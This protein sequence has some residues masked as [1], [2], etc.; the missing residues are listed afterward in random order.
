MISPTEYGDNQ[1]RAP[2]D[3]AQRLGHLRLRRK[4]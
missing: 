4:T 1:K 3:V 2:F